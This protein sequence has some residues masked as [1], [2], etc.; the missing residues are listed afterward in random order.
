MRDIPFGILGLIKAGDGVGRYVEVLND[1][2][3]TGGFLICTYADAD[4][5]PEAFDDWVE[6]RADVDVF[7][8]EC[9][10][11]IEW[12][13]LDARYY[14]ELRGGDGRPRAG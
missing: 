14:E 10:W 13:G 3:N 1:A 5:S 7:F 8:N 11:D 9:S 6:T 12:V 4:R 2:E